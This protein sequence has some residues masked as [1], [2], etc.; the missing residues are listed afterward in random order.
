MHIFF[1]VKNIN[2]TR[3]DSDLSSTVGAVQSWLVAD[4]EKAQLLH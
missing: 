2:S 1:V 4:G 3:A